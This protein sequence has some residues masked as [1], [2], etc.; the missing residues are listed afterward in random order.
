MTLVNQLKFY[1][2][3]TSEALRVAETQKVHKMELKIVFEAAKST[4]FFCNDCLK[5][6]KVESS[7]VENCGFPYT[8]KA[9]LFS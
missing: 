6:R 8:K 5:K 1:Y 4:L 9:I 2:V 3:N 7:S